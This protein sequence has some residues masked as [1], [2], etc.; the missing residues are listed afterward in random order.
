M[1]ITL[2]AGEHFARLSYTRILHNME[3]K[4]AHLR[5]QKVPESQLLTQSNVQ[6]RQELVQWL[7]GRHA[8]KNSTKGHLGGSVIS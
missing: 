4:A 6:Y 1:L 2:N 5:N 8:L 3:I 7:Y